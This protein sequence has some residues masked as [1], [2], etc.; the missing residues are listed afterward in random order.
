MLHLL[1]LL[2]RLLQRSQWLL[3]VVSRLDLPINMLMLPMW[4]LM[5]LLLRNIYLLLLLLLLLP[6]LF[7]L[8]H[9]LKNDSSPQ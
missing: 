1:L 9:P 8:L 7:L 6:L 5:L 2:R 3:V 4:L